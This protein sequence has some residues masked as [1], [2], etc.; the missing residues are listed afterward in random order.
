MKKLGGPVAIFTKGYTYET[1]AR[2]VREKLFVDDP[3]IRFC[4]RTGQPLWWKDLPKYQPVKP[5]DEAFWKFAQEEY[6]SDGI[7]IP[8]FGPNGRNGFVSM[9]LQNDNRFGPDNITY[10]LQIYC[11]VLH[12]QYCRITRDERGRIKLSNKEKDVMSFVVG[13]LSTAE[14]A[15]TMGLSVNTINTHLKRAYTKLGVTDRVSATLQFLGHGYH[16]E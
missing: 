15:E 9:G 4:L 2:Y 12:M 14:I 6:I 16:Y 1:Q 13:G 5:R 3:I 11:Q 7:S 8:T 10:I